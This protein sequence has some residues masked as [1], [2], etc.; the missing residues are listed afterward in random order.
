MSFT[1]TDPVR[2]AVGWNYIPNS[3]NVQGITIHYK[4]IS[5]AM[6]LNTSW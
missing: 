4:Y 5:A 6:P 1:V 3:Y 2:V